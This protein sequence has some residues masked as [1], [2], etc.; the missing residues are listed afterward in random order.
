MNQ[1]EKK[2]GLSIRRLARK[3]HAR[4]WSRTSTR[5]VVVFVVLKQHDDRD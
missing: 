3:R 4:K 2:V 1:E 5:L